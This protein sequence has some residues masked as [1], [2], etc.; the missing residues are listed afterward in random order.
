MSVDVERDLIGVG[1]GPANLSLAS[2]LTTAR[3]RGLTSITATFFECEATVFWH[4]LQMFPGSLMQ[5]EFYRDLVTPIDPTSKFSFLNYLKAKA[6]LDQFFCSSTIYP[7]R[8][9]FEDYFRWVAGQIGEV[10]FG[11]DVN[12]V[13]FDA[14]KNLFVVDAGSHGRCGTKHIVFGSGARPKSGVEQSRSYRI[15]DVSKL[16]AFT[17]PEVLNRILVVGGGQSA[18]ECLSYLLE[19]YSER[20]VRIDWVTSETS[21]R[22]LDT[23]NFSRETFSTAYAQMFSILSS[24]ARETINQDTKSVANG[25]TPLC[26]QTLYQRLYRLRHFPPSDKACP[27]VHLQANTKVVATH[28]EPAGVSVTVLIVSTGKTDVVVYDCVILCTGLDD[29]TILESSIIGPELRRRLHKNQDR[30]GYAVT[31]DGPPDRMIFLQSQNKVTHG[32]G[33]TSFVTAA[34]RN[35]AILNSIAGREIYKI[36]ESDLL[37][38]LK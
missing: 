15:V 19:R 2:L 22:A 23:S 6:R 5:T 31:W 8:R 33:D 9:E 16:L 26:A 35:A 29:E 13:D 36:D 38:A 24:E 37:V 27:V 20:P 21:F 34:G 28:E 14:T 25:I 1:A 11:V 10:I 32:L 3:E 4:S 18:A 17:F 12:C 30:D 7:T